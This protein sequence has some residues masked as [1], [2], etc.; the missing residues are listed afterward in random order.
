MGRIKI[1]VIGCGL[2]GQ[3]MHLPHLKELHDLYEVTALCD[4]SPATLK[5]VGD[6]YGIARRFTDHR[7]LLQEPVDAVMVLSADSHGQVILD[8]L[9]AGKHVFSEKPMCYTLG[10]ADAILAAERRA[11]TVCM[12]GYMKRHDPGLRYAQPL[13][14]KLQGLQAI[15][16]TVL[17]PSEANQVGHLDI[18][19]FADVPAAVR[20]RLR[21]DQDALIREAIG[22]FTPLERRVFAGNLLST[23]VHD[24][25]L[26][27]ALSGDPEDVLFTD[28]WHGGEAMATCLRYASGV[29]ATLSL[30]YLPDLAHYE[31]T[32]AFYARAE[33]VRL[34]FPSPFFRNMPTAVVVEGMEH[35]KAFEKRVT[36]SMQEAFKEELLHFAGCVTAGKTP[37]ST[38]AEAR[39]DVALLHRIFQAIPRPLAA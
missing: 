6:Y 30:Q 4:V 36:A 25:S 7:E 9:K 22:E 20:E 17:H 32:V 14:E 34:V 35:G 15:Q 8:G 23:L 1:G 26:L 18:R 24:I 39:G 21:A 12:V 29:R 16:I 31:E 37:V 3:V 11:G 38:V 27:R 33:R 28:V 2:I 10:E 13:I 5:Y 19:R